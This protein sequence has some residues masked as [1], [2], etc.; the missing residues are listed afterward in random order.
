[1]AETI[2]DTLEEAGHRIKE[3]ATKVGHKVG[4]TVE[5]V[6]D[7]AKEKAHQV[8]NRVDEAA[9][10]A[11]HRTGVNLRGGPDD[12]IRE[13]QSVYASCGTKVGKVDHVEGNSIKLTRNDSLDR[14]H[15]LIPRSWVASVDDSVHL[16]RDHIAVQR[17]WQTV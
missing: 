14:Q 12:S 13:H 16:D 7:W 5:E 4:E 17:E 6:S 9:Q 3:T 8:G 1:M 15:H 2:K 11:E 10:K